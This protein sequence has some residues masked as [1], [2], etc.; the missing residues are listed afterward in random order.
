MSDRARTLLAL[1]VVV[2]LGFVGWR[3]WRLQHPAVDGAA[4]A[5]DTAQAGLHSVTLWFADI[6]GDSL[7]SEVRQVQEAEGLHARV[8]RL[9]EMLV[10]G[11]VHGGIAVVPNGTAVLR[12]YLDDR[13]QLTLDL[14]LAFQ[15][16][17]HGGSREEDLVIGSL[18]RTIGSNLPEVK[19]VLFVCGGAP[20]AS[21]G[22]HLPLDR[23]IDPHEGF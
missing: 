14:S 12:A 8:S 19:R 16:G 3:T 6:G 9:V 21:L 17:F 23:P 10:V 22:G 20:I 15:Q 1:L 5:P 11:P 4:A 7:V 18:V 2:A 13:G